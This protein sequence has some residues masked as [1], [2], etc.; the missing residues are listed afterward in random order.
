MSY[1]LI[2]PST[3]AEG[4]GKIPSMAYASIYIS[5]QAFEK[6]SCTFFSVQFFLILLQTV[7]TLVQSF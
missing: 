6:R 3:I 7:L 1:P 4:N 5:Y 2:L